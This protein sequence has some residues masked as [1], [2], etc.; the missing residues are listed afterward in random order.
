MGIEFDGYFCRHFFCTE[1][2][3]FT[4]DRIAEW[5]DHGDRILCK[6]IF[7]RVSINPADTTGMAKINTFINPNW[8]CGNEVTTDDI[9]F[10]TVHLGIDQSH[11]ESGGDFILKLTNNLLN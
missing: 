5:G 4:G 3:T 10:D 7:Q 9:D 8:L 2:K 6:L 11:R 1:I